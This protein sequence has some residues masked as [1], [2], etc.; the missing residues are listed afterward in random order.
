MSRV[1]DLINRLGHQ[2][3]DLLRN[4]EI[5]SS[6][7]P[8]AE[9]IITRISGMIYHFK[10]KKID[11]SGFGIFKPINSTFANFVRDADDLQVEQYLKLL[12]QVKA[13]FAFKTDFWYCMP[14]NT[15]AYN[16]LGFNAITPVF[17]ADNI[18]ALDYF[19]G[20]YD[21]NGIWFE[22]LDPNC[23]A[24]KIESLKDCLKTKKLQKIKGLTPEDEM[25]LNLILK[26]KEEQ[27]EATFEGRLKALFAKKN[28]ILDS[29][30]ERG[31]ELEVK[32]KTH[33]GQPYTTW[34][35][36]SNFSV[37]SA[38]IC[39]N[40]EDHKFD[41]NSLIGIVSQGE[42]RDLIHRTSHNQ[43]VTNDFEEDD[44]NED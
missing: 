37:I 42:R 20:R 36:K 14:Q 26:K 4:Q 32:W 12:P 11:H 19:V 23:D 43:E 44:D 29:F 16:K 5:F 40:H 2:E 33:S 31:Q 9:T 41:L 28:A 30:K 35:K 8:T 27:E 22:N 13:I 21:G 39:L 38:G 3:K 34:V 10:I 15:S 1:N 7:S 17:N 25:I 18:E 6:F 24:I